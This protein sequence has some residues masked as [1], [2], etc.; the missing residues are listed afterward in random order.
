MDDPRPLP[1]IG[2][3]AARALAEVGVRNLDDLENADLAFLATLHGVGPKA[4]A[5]LRAELES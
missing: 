2:A 3:P 4:I 1:A 5:V